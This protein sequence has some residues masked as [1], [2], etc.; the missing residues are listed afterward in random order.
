MTDWHFYTDCAQ[1]LE[2]TIHRDQIDVG[3]SGHQRTY[4][5]SPYREVEVRAEVQAD[6]CV[7]E[8]GLALIAGC[9]RQDEENR[10]ANI[11]RITEVLN[12]AMKGTP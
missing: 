12:G 9:L 5:N 6:N 1:I 3:D 4:I 2:I 8:T 10:A 7:L 11:K